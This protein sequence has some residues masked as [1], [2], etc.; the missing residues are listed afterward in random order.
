LPGPLNSLRVIDFGQFIAGPLTAVMLADQGADVIHV[1]NPFRLQHGN[2][3][4]AFLNH[5]KRRITLDLS[6]ESDLNI[7]FDLIRGA[8]VLIENFRPGV[9]DRL[10]L[11]WNR[12]RELAPA[13]VYCS[14]PGFASDDPRAG[15]PGWEGVIDA[16]TGN[17]RVRLGEEPDGWDMSRPSYSVVPGA[18]NF[19]AFLA[20]FGIV[21][22]LTERARSGRGQRIEAP[23]YNAVFEAIGDAGAYV[24]AIG[25]PPP[26]RLR[27]NGSGTFR[28]RDG[29]YVQFNPLGASFRF[30]IWFLQ[31]AGVVHWAAE[32][33]TD[34]ARVRREPAL[35]VELTRRVAE[36]LLTRSAAEWEEL[37]AGA[38]VPLC[39]IRTP[40]EWLATEHARISQ[41]VVCREDP[42]LGSTWMAGLPVH[43]SGSPAPITGPRQL[44]DQGRTEVLEELRSRSAADAAQ[45][46]APSSAQRPAPYAGLRV[47]D[48]TQI[49]A[50]PSSGRLLAEFGA[51]VIKINSPKRPVSAHGIVNRGKRSILLDIESA[52]GQEIFWE[53]VRQADVLIQNFPFGTADRYGIG[54]DDVRARKPDIVYVSVSCY[55]YAGPWRSRRGYETQGQAVTGIMDGAGGDH[56]PAVLG[57]Y[58][59]LDYGTGVMAA[60][61][62]SLGI[63]H[64]AISGAGQH[65][66]A[67]LAQTGTYHQASFL[68]G[69]PGQTRT[70]PR[71]PEILGTGPLQRYYRANDGWFFLGADDTQLATVC[72][73]AGV[74]AK[75]AADTAGDADL[76]GLERIEQ[77]LA[78]AFALD[79]AEGWVT[80]L[81]AVG[82]GAHKVVELADL[83]VDPWARTNGLS[84][85]QMTDE[86]GEVT[87]PGIALRFSDTPPMLGKPAGRPGEDAESV[88]AAIGLADAIA[89]YEHAWVI[90]TTDLPTVWARP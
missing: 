12:I 34:L 27:G 50:G 72:T 49:L 5:G 9:M 75:A 45:A 80:V 77:L 56:G 28:C 39:M 65:V 82:V 70:Q 68:L 14:L 15:V 61:A 63:Y 42:V 18:S 69:Y 35:G 30:M 46:P 81:R 43:A 24:S 21:T 19:A 89:R 51:D 52:A 33:L 32:G 62:A 67:S 3:S 79:S 13:L 86:A 84:V 76:V 59:L 25:L 6:T 22:A 10:G 37:A 54:Y 58:N 41:E 26:P 74:S 71:G 83:M 44:P 2:E 16:A 1:D 48:L 85:V 55:G 88:L 90:Q 17:C 7:A 20:S 87:L 40:A 38:G 23:L 29:R 66:Y 57:P 8:D 60:F 11:G 78:T 4:D 47:V 36:L 31:A 64:R 53:L 73:A